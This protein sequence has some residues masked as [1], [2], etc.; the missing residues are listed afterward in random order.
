MDTTLRLLVCLACFGL[1]LDPAEATSFNEYRKALLSVNPL[2]LTPQC[3]IVFQ[4]C[5]AKLVSMISV[6][7]NVSKRWEEYQSIPCIK[8]AL[9]GGFPD[10]TQDCTKT[11]K[12]GEGVVC[13]LTDEVLEVYGDKNKMKPALQCLLD[14]AK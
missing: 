1:L 4:K 11:G 9:A 6:L 8:K 10:Y 2:T 14:N 13:Q 5:A 3:R 7:D 12:Y